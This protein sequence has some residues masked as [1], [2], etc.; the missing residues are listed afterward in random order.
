MKNKSIHNKKVLFLTGT[1]AD[2]GKLKSLMRSI[3]SA[4]GFDLHIFA[5]GMHTLKRYGDTKT[6]IIKDGFKN[7][8]IYMNQIEE[9]PM[10]LILANTI[11]GL[12]RYVKELSPDLLIVHGD[13]VEALA[14][15][16]VGSLNNII[17]GHVEG[18]EVSGTID[19]SIRHAITKLSHIHFVSNHDAQNRLIQ[20]GEDSSRIFVIGSPDIDAMMKESDLSIEQVKKRYDIGF[21]DFAIALFHPVTTEV[22]KMKQHAA[23]FVKALIESNQ[24]YIVI[25]PNN[26]LGQSYIF[27]AYEQIKD[28]P[29]FKLFPSIRF[30]YFVELLKNAN[31]I[32][33]NSSVGIHE[34]P[35]LGKPSINIGTRQNE[36][37]KYDTILDVNYNVNEIVSAIDKLS[38]MSYFPSTNYFG[39]GNSAENFLTILKGEEVWS[40]KTQKRFIDI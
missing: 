15:A 34:A 16:I 10:D 14:G 40:T 5:T 24:N 28:L 33:G 19:D 1:R 11:N 12:S 37:F 27:D 4:E 20:L 9:E 18:G 3:E 38:G 36:R 25:Y 32:I 31:F 23:I 22:D 2:Y 35:V 26:D 39:N 8:Q 7:L 21:N 17:V 30:E 29:R 6:E 13:R